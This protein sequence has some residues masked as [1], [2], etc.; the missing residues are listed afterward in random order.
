MIKEREKKRVTRNISSGDSNDM[1]SSYE[2]N[3][4]NMQKSFKDRMENFSIQ[5]GIIK[6]EVTRKSKKKKKR[7]YLKL[8][9]PLICLMANLTE[10][11]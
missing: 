9:T 1:K 2:I 10:L 6:R 4:I 7:C 11:K 3:M 8:K 5:V